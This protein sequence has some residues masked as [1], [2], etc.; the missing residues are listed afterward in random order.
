MQLEFSED[1]DLQP[2]KATQKKRRGGRPRKQARKGEVDEGDAEDKESGTKK[3]SSTAEC[4][5]GFYK[6]LTLALL[7]DAITYMK[8]YLLTC[9][10]FPSTRKLRKCAKRFFFA[11]CQ[12]KL[13][14]NWKGALEF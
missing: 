13:G 11:A 5:L 1:E 4:R 9:N 3:R 14:A 12:V 10:G 2:S 7:K 6:D 8:L